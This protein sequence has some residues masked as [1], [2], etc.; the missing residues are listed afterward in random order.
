MIK[1]SREAEF[2]IVYVALGRHHIREAAISSW[3]AKR[4]MPGVAVSIVTD[5]PVSCPHFDRVLPFDG[6]T[7]E[8]H[9]RVAKLN[10]V[11]AILSAPTECVLYAD[12][13]TYFLGDVSDVWT[14]APR[15]DI[16][17]VHDTWQYAEI[18]RQINHGMPH[19]DPPPAC[20]F[21]NSGILFVN[22]TEAVRAFLEKWAIDTW[23]DK[24]LSR[25]QLLFREYIYNSNLRVH[26]LPNI[27]NARFAEPIHLSGQIK[28]AHGYSGVER[29]NWRESSPF[30]SDFLNSTYHNR[31]F[32]P[33]DG[34]LISIEYLGGTH[35]RFLSR[36]YAIREREEF[37]YPDL[38]F[39]VEH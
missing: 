10:K 24:R 33:H 12:A 25:D 35:K 31:I 16:A 28:I 36:H 2:T 22:K 9:V 19:D 23:Q 18:Y 38:R 13:D 3:S 11:N 8:H 14:S 21:F 32:S 1:K 37:L 4:H 7:S 29:S 39:D 34:R 26:V 30:I 20:P 15:F 5:E 27:Y 17:A 6:K